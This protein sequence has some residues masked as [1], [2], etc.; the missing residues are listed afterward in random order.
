M[1][2]LRYAAM[3]G[4]LT[5]FFLGGA[6]LTS[7]PILNEL[8]IFS[9]TS[10]NPD[11]PG[12]YTIIETCL[13]LSSFLISAVAAW[14]LI[15]VK[16]VEKEQMRIAG[17]FYV[18]FFLVSLV[19]LFNRLMALGI[20][21]DWGL[22]KDSGCRN[23][24]FDG[25]PVERYERY[26]KKN[27]TLKS[28][29]IFNGFNTLNI[30][31]GN[32]L[33]WANYVNY[34]SAQRNVLLQA[35]QSAGLTDLA[36]EDIPYYHD[37]WYWGCHEICH[38]RYLLNR[39]WLWFSF[40]GMMCYVLTALLLFCAGE[41]QTSISPKEAPEEEPNDEEELEPFIPDESNNKDS[42]SSSEELGTIKVSL[43]L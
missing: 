41:D 7:L 40:I 31:G 11:T 12:V 37:A 21:A 22:S 39:S 16:K 5:A 10:V 43:R 9:D 2:I 29:C 20:L 38:D 26:S 8:N 24:N 27:I 14:A 30:D 32:K 6:Y 17:F 33:D 28:E 25:N 35:A 15:G 42:P 36:L 1:G 23:P 3:L 18:M 13:A 4:T 19:I 34:D